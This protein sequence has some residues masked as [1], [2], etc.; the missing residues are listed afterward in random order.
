[1][2]VRAKGALAGVCIMRISHLLSRSAGR[3]PEI[4][5]ARSQYRGEGRTWRPEAAQPY[6]GMTFVWKLGRKCAETERAVFRAIDSVL[7]TGLLISPGGTKT[8]RQGLA[9]TPIYSALR[10]IAGLPC[11]A[12][13]RVCDLPVWIAHAVW[14]ALWRRSHRTCVPARW[15]ER[16]SAIVARGR[17]RTAA[18]AGLDFIHRMAGPA[19]HEPGAPTDS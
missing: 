13:T 10:P 12:E 1:M 14:S 9:L 6:A 3:R 15:S 4:S 7:K 5:A 19:V 2:A 16:W 11:G 17:P 8:R 18:L